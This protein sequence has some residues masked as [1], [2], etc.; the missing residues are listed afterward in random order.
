MRRCLAR[1]AR[2]RRARNNFR[3][4]HRCTNT[5]CASA[6]IALI[7]APTYSQ[8]FCTVVWRLMLASL[9]APRQRRAAGDRQAAWA[10]HT[11]TPQGNTKPQNGFHPGALARRLVSRLHAFRSSFECY[12]QASSDAR[13]QGCKLKCSISQLKRLPPRHPHRCRGCARS[14]H[15]ASGTSERGLR[16]GR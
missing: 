13:A 8:L 14:F 7:A 1:E 11:G 5:R 12:A 16:T 15:R 4:A 2:S 3:C 6:S 10:A 9:D